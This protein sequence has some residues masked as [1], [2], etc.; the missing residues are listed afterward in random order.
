MSIPLIYDNFGYEYHCKFQRCIYSKLRYL[1]TCYTAIFQIMAPSQLH[2]TTVGL[3]LNRRSGVSEGVCETS[4]SID[5][6][7]LLLLLLMICQSSFLIDISGIYIYI[8]FCFSMFN[9]T[10]R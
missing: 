7:D 1:F 4:L 5:E 10:I 2:F 8:F 3:K 9:G 6:S